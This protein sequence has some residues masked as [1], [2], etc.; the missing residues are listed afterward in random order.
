MEVVFI[1]ST[2]ED[3][4]I[5]AQVSESKLLFLLCVNLSTHVIYVG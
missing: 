1:F 2:K 4:E 5:S 3:V